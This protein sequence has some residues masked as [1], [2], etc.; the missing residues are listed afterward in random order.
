MNSRQRVRCAFSH[1]QPDRPPCDYIATPEI[2]AGLLRHF[3]LASPEEIRE[4][5]AETFTVSDKVELILRRIGA[6]KSIR[7]TELFGAN[8]SK[9]EIICTFLALLELIRLRQVAVKQRERFGEI[10]IEGIETPAVA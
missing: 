7:F 10:A 3:G 5:Y 9:H 2:H 1:V 4:I 8:A 6:E